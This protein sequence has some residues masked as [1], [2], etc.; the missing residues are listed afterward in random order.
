MAKVVQWKF[1]LPY[2]SKVPVISFF[3]TVCIC[4]DSSFWIEE[5][6]EENRIPETEGSG[7][8]I[9]ITKHYARPSNCTRNLPVL[10]VSKGLVTWRISSRAEISA[11]L[12]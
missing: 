11:Q 7:R 4:K 6:S 3:T 12:P 8:N 2:E 1:I 9:F 5:A 10:P